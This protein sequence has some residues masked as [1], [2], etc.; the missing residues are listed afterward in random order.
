MY[1]YMYRAKNTIRNLIVGTSNIVILVLTFSFPLC[2][3]R[4][5]FLDFYSNSN[6]IMHRA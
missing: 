4:L 1:V 2:L 6:A 5:M 3:F